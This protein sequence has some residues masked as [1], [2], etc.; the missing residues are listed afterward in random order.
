MFKNKNGARVLP[1]HLGPKKVLGMAKNIF[2]TCI[3]I[4]QVSRLRKTEKILSICY[5]RYST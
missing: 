3:Q 4:P 2:N 5:I 1:F